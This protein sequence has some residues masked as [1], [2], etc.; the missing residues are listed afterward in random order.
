MPYWGQAQGTT[1][2]DLEDLEDRFAKIRKT[3]QEGKLAQIAAEG[4]LGLEG[5]RI[6]SAG[7]EPMR[8]AAASQYGAEAGKA[9]AETRNIDLKT[10]L[11]TGAG[12]WFDYQRKKEAGKEWETEFDEPMLDEAFQGYP[13]GSHANE[14]S[15]YEPG[16]Y[17]VATPSVET[18]PEY[19]KWMGHY[20]KRRKLR[21]D[22]WKKDPFGADFGR[23]PF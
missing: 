20:A 8:L 13:I 23:I 11:G 10:A 12:K 19:A 15:Q 5:K 22:I 7:M 18:D 1:F 21:E 9:G 2:E 3:R 6:E 16:P 17:N 14:P 4:A